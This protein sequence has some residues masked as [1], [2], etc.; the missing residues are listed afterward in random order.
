MTNAGVVRAAGDATPDART[1]PL[2]D[3]RTHRPLPRHGPPGP[4]ELTLTGHL[5]PRITCPEGQPC[6][7]A[8]LKVLAGY[9]EVVDQWEDNALIGVL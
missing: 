3:A 6:S 4:A 9:V 1:P 5:P 8:H 2:P 7:D